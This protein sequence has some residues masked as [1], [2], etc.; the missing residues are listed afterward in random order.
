MSEYGEAWDSVARSVF[1]RVVEKSAKRLRLLERVES[2]W[3][4]IVGAHS[5]MCGCDRC[6]LLSA[7]REAIKG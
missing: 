2:V 6:E 3:L 7:I 5:D 4:D 1:E